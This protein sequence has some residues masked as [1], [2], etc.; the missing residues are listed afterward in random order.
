MARR[1]KVWYKRV[2]LS[3]F[4]HSNPSLSLCSTEALFLF[5]FLF[6][7]TSGAMAV[8]HQAPPSTLA[9]RPSA[10][11]GFPVTTMPKTTQVMQNRH[12]R[13]C[14]LPSIHTKPM[15]MTPSPCRSAE[16]EFGEAAQASNAPLRR[17]RVGARASKDGVFRGSFSVVV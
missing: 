15:R 11:G 12:H 9:P 2:T 4:P 7:D 17:W 14:L 16:A 13:K 5:L 6:L 3:S 10:D 8:E 1:K